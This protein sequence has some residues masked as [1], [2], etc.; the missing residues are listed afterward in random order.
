MENNFQE[1]DTELFYSLYLDIRKYYNLFRKYEK[2]DI[3]AKVNAWDYILHDETD[4]LFFEEQ[5]KHR[6]LKCSD[7]YIKY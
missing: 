7:L 1:K 5:M 6:N 4:N 2:N 3:D